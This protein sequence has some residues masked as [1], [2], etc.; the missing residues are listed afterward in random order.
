MSFE[1]SGPTEPLFRS[2]RWR[3][4]LASVEAAAVAGIVCALAWSI[5][6]RGLL[7]SLSVDSTPAEITRFY[8][9]PQRG[10][11]A[12]LLLQIILIGT[13][14]FLWFS[15]ATRRPSRGV[16]LES[17]PLHDHTCVASCE[18]RQATGSSLRTF[19]TPSARWAARS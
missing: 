13:V 1:S 6:I 8:S 15:G 12:L 3:G 14:A 7:A 17:R 4:R 10:Y 19:G 9:D 18:Q 5:G 2:R 11:K 16:A